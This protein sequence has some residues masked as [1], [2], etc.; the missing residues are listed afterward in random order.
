MMYWPWSRTAWMRPL[1]SSRDARYWDLRSM[2]S[3]M[4]EALS[5]ELGMGGKQAA[6]AVDQLVDLARMRAGGFA[7]SRQPQRQAFAEAADPSDLARGN[8]GHQ[9]E[10]G[11]IVLDHRAG[12]DE[13]IGADRHAAD[14]GGVGA[15]AGAV[16][17]QGTPV[18]VLAD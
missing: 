5:L 3:M 15:D 2:N 10:V 4:V 11:H 6:D 16:P 17:D 7:R 18:L 9:G 1:I 14:D 12:A 8:P 13:G